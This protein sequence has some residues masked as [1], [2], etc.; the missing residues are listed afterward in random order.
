LE[1]G[2][3]RWEK[4]KEKREGNTMGEVSEPPKKKEPTFFKI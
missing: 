1:P 3:A 4:K 2:G